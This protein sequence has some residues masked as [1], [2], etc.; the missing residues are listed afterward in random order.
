MDIYERQVRVEAP[1]AEVW[2]STRQAT[3][4]SH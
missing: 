2:K 4:W 1:L 3:G